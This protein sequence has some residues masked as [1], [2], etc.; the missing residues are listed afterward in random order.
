M[1]QK[2]FVNSNQFDRTFDFLTNHSY[3]GEIKIFSC[4]RAALEVLWSLGTQ[5][6]FTMQC[7]V[8]SITVICVSASRKL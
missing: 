4:E 3:G 6:E 1:R 5:T 2:L 7:N 8:M